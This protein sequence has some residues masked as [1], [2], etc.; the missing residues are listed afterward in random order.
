MATERLILEVRTV[1]TAASARSLDSISRSASQANKTLALLRSTLVLVAGVRVISGFLK[2]GDT[3]TNIRNRLRLVTESEEQLNVVQSRLFQISQDTRSSFEANAILFNRLAR[4]AVGLDKTFGELLDV[5]KGISQAI[6]IAGATSQEAR[7]SLIQFSQGLASGTLR[8]DELRSVAEQLPTLAA[9]IAKEFS[10]AGLTTARSLGVTEKALKDAQQATGDL[11]GGALVAFAKANDGILKTPKIIAAVQNALVGFG[12]DFAKIGVTVEQ[13]FTKFNNVLILFVGNISK[14]VQLGARLDIALQSIARNLDVIVLSLAAIGILGAFNLL[15]GTVVR[16]LSSLRSVVVFLTSGLLSALNGLG[17]VINGLRFALTGLV[18]VFSL[19]FIP[20][21]LIVTGLVAAFF[22]VREAIRI[23]EEKFGSLG[24]LF[25]KVAGGILGSLRGLVLAFTSLPDAIADVAIKSANFLRRNFGE[26]INFIIEQLNVIPGIDIKPVDVGEFINSF[27]GEAKKVVNI[28]SNSIQEGF[29]TGISSSE[30]VKSVEDFIN[31]FR[32]FFAGGIIP[33]EFS[34]SLLNAIVGAGKKFRDFDADA[35]KVADS[36]RRIRASVDPAEAAF[37]K[38]N[39]A[40]EAF[41]KVTKDNEFITTG[42]AKETL[43]LLAENLLNVVDT[44]RQYVA[45]LNVVD[46]AQSKLNLTTER[47]AL[48]RQKLALARQEEIDKVLGS[49]F[50]IIKAET[51]RLKIQTELNELLVNNRTTTDQAAEAN[52][53]LLRTFFGFPPTIEQALESIDA[54]RES[55]DAL[56]VSAVQVAQKQRELLIAANQDFTLEGGLNTFFLELN[57]NVE[58]VGKN[59]SEIMTNA[60]QDAKD[61]LIDFIQTGEL[62]FANFLKNLERALL[63]SA[64]DSLL[65]GLGTG[66]G[67]GAKQSPIASLVNAGIGAI[68]GIFGGGGALPA[69]ALGAF[70]GGGNFTVGPGTSVGSTSGVDN[71]IVAFRARDGENVSVT[72]K[73]QG[74]APINI[75]FNISTPDAD[76][77]RKSQGQIMSDL[78]ASLG[79]H[80]RRNG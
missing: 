80:A 72:P 70:A 77:F 21:I 37:K 16:F 9:A 2:F 42:F 7:N 57:Q 58:N 34:D 45:M 33:K 3:L 78:H 65:A 30:T 48:A 24:A 43:R 59:I 62:N 49:V 14:S 52:K 69:S 56:G 47:A 20:V 67:P 79:R 73:G 39:D 12:Q 19:G 8:G 4:S 54:L 15:T 60:W 28:I 64:L 41:S 68:G 36:I 27:E 13:A 10:D 17:A 6:A 11:S 35:K 71:R 53:R 22:A 25:D 55:Q 76:S 44:E 40:Q 46:E 29:K 32:S 5:T 63:N 26:A 31:K 23:V 61:A 50:P 74:M 66:G 38:I 75:T 51:E 18:S 1:G